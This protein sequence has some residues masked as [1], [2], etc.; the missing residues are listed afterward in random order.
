MRSANGKAKNIDKKR[1]GQI[2]HCGIWGSVTF[3]SD[4]FERTE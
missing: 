3:L 1:F 4:E 2:R